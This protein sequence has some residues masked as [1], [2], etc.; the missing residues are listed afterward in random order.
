MVHD[1]SCRTAWHRHAACA[2]DV[3]VMVVLLAPDDPNPMDAMT[4]QPRQFLG[5]LVV[6]KAVADDVIL[7]LYTVEPEEVDQV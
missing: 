1:G 7:S 5:H 2:E 4:V 6:A 3:A